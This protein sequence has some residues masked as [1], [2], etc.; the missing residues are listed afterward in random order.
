M[1]Q[2]RGIIIL[3][4]GKPSSLNFVFLNFAAN[5]VQ[6]CIEAARDLHKLEY[7]IFNKYIRPEYKGPWYL[8]CRF[9]SRHSHG[10]IDRSFMA[11]MRDL[12]S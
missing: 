10:R 6:E 12:K 1:Q 9:M 3:Q 11:N 7:E 8:F 2:V 5:C 4:C